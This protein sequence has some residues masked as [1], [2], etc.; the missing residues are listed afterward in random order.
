MRGRRGREKEANRG[1]E[2]ERERHGCGRMRPTQSRTLCVRAIYIAKREYKGG[3]ASG[4]RVKYSLSQ[5]FCVV[6]LLVA[7]KSSARAGEEESVRVEAPF[8]LFYPLPF[9]LY[10]T[11]C[12]FFALSPLSFLSHPVGEYSRF[13]KI[14]SRSE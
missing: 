10:L 9:P 5:F 2:R 7:P 4:G 11:S 8:C 12:L 1:R 13:D 14:L 3:K 6:I